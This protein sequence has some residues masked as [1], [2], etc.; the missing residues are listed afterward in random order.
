MMDTYKDSFERF[1]DV[2]PPNGK[3]QLKRRFYDEPFYLSYI[4]GRVILNSV[5]SG[6]W[7]EREYAMCHLK[8]RKITAQ[9][10]LCGD[11]LIHENEFVPLND[12][13]NIRDNMEQINLD[14]AERNSKKKLEKI[15]AMK[16]FIELIKESPVSAML[17]MIRIIREKIL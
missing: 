2:L 13:S 9:A 4:N 12:E 6:I 3:K 5:K 16:R 10:D 14:S 8:K 11:F 17:R 7:H 15:E 1:C